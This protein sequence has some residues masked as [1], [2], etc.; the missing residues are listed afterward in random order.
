MLKIEKTTILLLDDVAERQRLETVFKGK[1]RATLLS[2]LD[3]FLQGRFEEL[4]LERAN[5]SREMAEY[6]HPVIDDVLCDTLM[7]MARVAVANA[8]PEDNSELL[9]RQRAWVE[10]RGLPLHAELSAY[11]RFAKL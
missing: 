5:M 9:Q 4:A 7:R 10:N 11:P 8:K 3:R 6:L 2:V 1:T